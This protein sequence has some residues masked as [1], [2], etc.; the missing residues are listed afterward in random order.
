MVDRTDPPIAAL[1]AAF[2]GAQLLGLEL[3][4]RY[5][6]LAVTIEPDEAA[7]P[8]GSGACGTAGAVDRRRQLLVSPV[9]TVLASLRRSPGGGG[10]VQVLTFADDQLVD[11]AAAFGGA[12]LAAPLF[13]RPEP[14]PGSWAPTWS[15]EGRSTAGDGV[16]RTLTVRVR[17]ED[18]T[19]ELALDLFVRFDE[20]LIRDAAGTELERIVPRGG[21]DLGLGLGSNLGLG[22]GRASREPGTDA[23]PPPSGPSSGGAASGR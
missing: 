23:T 20:V 11:V 9:S 3:D 21:L 22:G 5:R 7:D 10:P 18:G 12:P 13:G 4:T 16:G 19:G 15:L 2:A 8:W 14:R 1:E 17:A 6:V